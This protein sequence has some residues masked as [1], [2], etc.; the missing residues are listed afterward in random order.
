MAFKFIAGIDKSPLK[1]MLQLEAHRLGPF[2]TC[3]PE[4]IYRH[5]PFDFLNRLIL[6]QNGHFKPSRNSEYEIGA[7]TISPYA[8][9]GQDSALFHLF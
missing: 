1:K 6:A 7:K 4:Y 3:A 2:V 9:F 8:G 5:F